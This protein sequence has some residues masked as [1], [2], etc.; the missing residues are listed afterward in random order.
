VSVKP[1]IQVALI[2]GLVTSSALALRGASPTHHAHLSNDLL[3]HQA[4]QTTAR[5]RVIVHGDDAAL[6][7]L[8]SRH[9]LALVRRLSGGAVVLAN[10]SELAELATDTS[11]DHLSGDLPVKT[12]MSVTNLSTAADQVRTGTSGLLGIGAIPAVTGKGIGVAVIDSGV[13]F[14][15]ALS[16]NVLANVSLITGDSSFADTFGHGTHIAGIIAGS[17]TPARNVTSL[18]TGG[19]APDAQIINIRV[20]GAD[21]VGLTSDVIAGVQWAIAHRSQYNIRV[22][23]L[24]LGHPVVESA[25]TDPLCEVVAE[26]VQA[27][28]V[29]VAAA[30]NDGVNADGSMVLGGIMSPGNSPWAITVGALNT[31]GT[32]KRSDDTVTTYSSR[33]PTRYDLA[34]KPDVAAP[35]N[36]IISLEV[37]GSNLSTTYQYLHKAG[38]GTNAYMQLSG[39]SM[40]T[41]VVSG[42]VALMLQGTP[43]LIPAQV[44][45][46]LQTT[47]TYV[48]NGGLLGAG[49]GSVNFWNARKAAASGLLGNL[50][51]SLVGGLLSPSSGAAYWDAGTMTGRVY[52]GTGLRLLSPLDA[53]LAWLNPSLLKFGDLN[54][55]GLSNSLAS[56]APKRLLYGEVADWTNDSAIMWGSTIYDPQGQAI[57]W[58]SSDT[59]DGTAIMW[60]SSMTSPDPR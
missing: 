26:A 37:T 42:G 27:G 2:L 3:G 33:G 34:V 36:K 28:I 56:I 49:A 12:W 1:F 19:I 50:V 8:A 18:Y 24:S 11:L 57:M 4:R 29:V 52:G 59:T 43:G 44:K 55:V 32:V 13:S 39:T 9:H 38:S 54:L 40:A 23:N 53:L 25:T 14:H 60:G 48:P 22:I 21:G 41:P 20:L 51:S 17:G 35:G 47:A 31:W 45:L 7:A 30:G 16:R 5:A 15:D 46:A 58:G 10:S 6:D